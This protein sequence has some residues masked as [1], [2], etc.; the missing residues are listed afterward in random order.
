MFPQPLFYNCESLRG[1]VHCA[2]VL[3]REGGFRSLFRGTGATLL[4]DVPSSGMWFMSYE[5][6]TNY[7]NRGKTR[8]E[9]IPTSSVTWDSQFCL[10]CT[11]I[12]G[13]GMYPSD[14]LPLLKTPTGMEYLLILFAPHRYEVSP[15]VTLFCGGMAGVCNWLVALPLGRRHIAKQLISCKD[16]CLFL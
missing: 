4:R 14:N 10:N 16:F 3:Y 7:L 1:P 12:H 8:S 2:Q 9:I 6:F 5:G 13:G 15:W 11:I